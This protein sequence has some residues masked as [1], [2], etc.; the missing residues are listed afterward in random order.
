MR[1]GGFMSLEERTSYFVWIDLQ[2]K[3]HI[4]DNCNDVK[5]EIGEINNG[6]FQ[7]ISGRRGPFSRRNPRGASPEH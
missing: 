6:Y 5:N 7:D 3:I 2:G 4:A 1:L